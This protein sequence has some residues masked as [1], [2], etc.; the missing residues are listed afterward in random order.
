MQALALHGHMGAAV[1]V[2]LCHACQLFWF[3]RHESLR[4]APGSTLALFSTIGEHASSPPAVVQEPLR[5]PRCA[6]RLA[7]VNDLQ[8]RTR[9]R[10]WRC[11]TCGGRLTSFLDFLKEKEF[12]R[13]MPPE[14][15]EELRRHVQTTNCSNC[16]AAIN[17]MTAESCTHCGSP[18]T[19]LDMAQVEQLVTR[20][21][22]AAQPKTVDP[23]PAQVPPHERTFGE[24]EH[25]EEWWRD[26][27]ASDLVSA[28]LA[29]LS[30]WLRKGR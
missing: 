20:L 23:A 24:M 2:E 19:L 26:A 4:L 15:L 27:S 22:N 25:Q 17:L 18:L 28:G 16:G 3:D 29:A 1:T 7:H 12:I 14:R 30:R 8:R 5:C 10:Y 11:G 21:R 6:R 13:P 9:F